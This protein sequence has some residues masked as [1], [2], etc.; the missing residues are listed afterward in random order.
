MRTGVDPAWLAI[1]EPFDD[2]ALDRG[3]IAQIEAWAASQASAQP[4]R[5]VDLGG[6]T[7]AALRRASRWLRRR[8]I[9]AFTV[10]SDRRVLAH[11][12]SAWVAEP[13]ADVRPAQGERSD[14]TIAPYTVTLGCKRLA[15]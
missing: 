15:I 13:G 3:L 14:Q 4:I 9:E 1:R 12:R 6:G 7:G 8:S 10:D 11:G 2:R 5:V